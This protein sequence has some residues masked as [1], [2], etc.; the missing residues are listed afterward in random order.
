[1]FCAVNEAITV[2]SFACNLPNLP[3]IADVSLT[4]FA[5]GKS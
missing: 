1:M 4:I 3:V 2:F 5:D